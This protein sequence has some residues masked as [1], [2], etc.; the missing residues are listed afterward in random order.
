MFTQTLALK[1]TP[2]AIVFGLIKSRRH[3]KVVAQAWRLKSRPAVREFT[4]ALLTPP[5]FV[6]ADE[7][8]MEETM[9]A[10]QEEKSRLRLNRAAL[11]KAA[12]AERRTIE[13]NIEPRLRAKL[14]FGKKPDEN[15][16]RGWYRRKDYRRKAR[17]FQ[18]WKHRRKT[19]FRVVKINFQQDAKFVQHLSY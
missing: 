19:K 10:S 2:P 11:R 5:K 17:F 6:K 14:V 4:P 8:T 13:D 15:G 12:L 18:S 16:P 7:P 1:G 3:I 9:L